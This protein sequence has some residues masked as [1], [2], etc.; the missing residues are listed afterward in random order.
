MAKKFEAELGIN[1]K[2]FTKG[3]QEA[4]GSITKFGKSLGKISKIIGAV[5]SAL[6][7]VILVFKSTEASSDRLTLATETVKGAYQ[8]LMQTIATGD[9]GG[10]IDNI[11]KTAKAYRD[12]AAAQDMMQD[13]EASNLVKKSYLEKTLQSARVAAAAAEDPALKAQYLKE[14][15]ATQKAITDITVSEIQARITAD[16]NYFRTKTGFDDEANDLMIKNFHK[17][18]GNWE[19]FYGENGQLALLQIQKQSFAYKELAGTLSDAEKLQLRQVKAAVVN[20]ELFKEFQDT[21]KEGRFNEYVKAIGELNNAY[22]TGDAELVRLTSSLRAANEAQKMFLA[23]IKKMDSLESLNSEADS[24]SRI[25]TGKSRKENK[26]G[27]RPNKID[28][29]SQVKEFSS[30]QEAI[31]SLSATFSTFF[32]DVNLGFQGMIDGIITGLKRLVMELLAKAAILGILALI[33]GVPLSGEMFKNLLFG[34]SIGSLLK[35]G[36]IGGGGGTSVPMS[37]KVEF[38]LKGKDLYGS[39]NRYSSELATGT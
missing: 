7:A 29:S 9:W 27:L 21:M 14:A 15:I 31:M 28:V 30:M 16:E 8:G 33:T 20:L 36:A 19:T 23:T 10:L 25:I 38:V 22:A 18:A 24:I 37:G 6:G 3:L 35:G 12:L 39:V 34:D 11:T 4:E 26:F 1:N 5:G 32:S 2:G 17:I 13:I